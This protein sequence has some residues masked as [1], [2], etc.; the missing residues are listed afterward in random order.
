MIQ[1]KLNI[2]DLNNNINNKNNKNHFVSETQGDSKSIQKSLLDLK[3]SNN[4]NTV[5]WK[6]QP[7]KNKGSDEPD[8]DLKASAV[9]QKENKQ[10]FKE[11]ENDKTSKNY[12]KQTSINNSN[13]KDN[14]T[15]D[16]AFKNNSNQK[17]KKNKKFEIDENS[18]IELK[19]DEDDLNSETG[20]EQLKSLRENLSQSTKEIKEEKERKTV[21]KENSK[22]FDVIDVD[23]I[24]R[25]QADDDMVTSH[26][27]DSHNENSGMK[28]KR[29]ESGELVLTGIENEKEDENRK[30]VKNKNISN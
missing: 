22:K 15:P 8:K 2:I 7:S 21:K 5:Q 28:S 4:G 29:K 20:K 16:K 19:Y 26:K 25:E 18:N 12:V 27:N 10:G 11:N 30:T 13:T 3:E 23:N 24:K 14:Y 1:N 9:V 17:A 6:N